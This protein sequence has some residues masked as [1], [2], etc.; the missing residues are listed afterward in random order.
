VGAEPVKSAVFHV[1]RDHA[2]ALVI[3]HNQVKSKVLDEEVG[4]MAEGL[5]I[6][7]MK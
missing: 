7:R 5:T 3:L 4:I 6:K 1:K 2:Y